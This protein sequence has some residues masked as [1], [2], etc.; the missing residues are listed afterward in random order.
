MS[1]E[2]TTRPGKTYDTVNGEA[3]TLAKLNLLGNPSVTVNRSSIGT[4][5]LIDASVT[6][7]KLSTD[8]IAQINAEAILGD[9]SVTAAKIATGAVT[10]AKLNQDV[11]DKVVIRDTVSTTQGSYLKYTANQGETEEV[12]ELALFNEFAEAVNNS[13]AAATV[14]VTLANNISDLRRIHGSVM[15]V[16]GYSGSAQANCVG[17]FNFV[18]NSSGTWDGSMTGMVVHDGANSSNPLGGY[19]T[20]GTTS[21]ASGN[22]TTSANTYTLTVSISGTTLTA[23]HTQSGSTQDSQNIYVA[24]TVE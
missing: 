23:T 7:D 20:S 22:F 8:V 2:T 13:A 9:G 11:L 17:H 21:L 1:G 10:Y 12:T 4:D 24:A 15:Q 6:S 16:F 3:N 14:N 19:V 5:E 18:K